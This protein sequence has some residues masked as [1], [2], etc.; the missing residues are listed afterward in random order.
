MI[1]NIRFR[2]FDGLRSFPGGFF[3]HGIIQRKV[4]NQLL[5]PLRLLYSHAA[6]FST[7]ALIRLFSNAYLFTCFGD[8]E[9][10]PARI[11]VREVF[12]TGASILAVACPVCATMLDEGING[13]GLEDSIVVKDIS[14]LINFNN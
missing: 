3:Q 14:E 4:G 12:E 7:P 10:S 2:L 9:N 8:G 6:V 13:E 11:R 5:E 1:C